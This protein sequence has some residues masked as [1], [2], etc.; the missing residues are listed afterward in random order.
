MS[1]L[2]GDHGRISTTT[3]IFVASSITS[4]WVYTISALLA[5]LVTPS[6]SKATLTAAVL[7]YDMSL[8]TDRSDRLSIG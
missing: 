6:G 1:S 7:H 3:S 8:V 4:S 2:A 5:A